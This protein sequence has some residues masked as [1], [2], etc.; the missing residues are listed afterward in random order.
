LS[1]KGVAAIESPAFEI[2]LLILYSLNV[3]HF[4][5]MRILLILLAIV[6][7]GRAIILPPRCPELTR[8]VWPNGSQSIQFDPSTND[9]EQWLQ[10]VRHTD[11]PKCQQIRVPLNT[12]IIML[13]T[14]C[15]PQVAYLWPMHV[16]QFDCAYVRPGAIVKNDCPMLD[17]PTYLR[18]KLCLPFKQC[19][20]VLP[21][22]SAP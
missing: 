6:G 20:G 5:T 13:P 22:N 10:P 11:G 14:P 16:H 15:C 2:V 18:F 12:S 17:V 1:S 9:Y 19:N 3:V 8:V 21:F 4:S 7:C